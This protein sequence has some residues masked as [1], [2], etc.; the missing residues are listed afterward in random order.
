M[1]EKE[2]LYRKVNTRTRGVRHGGGEYKWLRHRKEESVAGRGSTRAGKRNGRDYTPLFKFLISGVG[3]D[4]DEVYGEAVRRLD[5]PEPIFWL[6]ARNEAEKAA[7][8]RATENTCFS[9]LFIDENNRLAVVDPDLRVE[10]MVP[11][12]AC[13]THSFNGTPF[14]RKFGSVLD[15]NCPLTVHCEQIGRPL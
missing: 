14:I 11:S 12:C 9:G 5:S 1:R 7:V 3:R 6:V 13:C 10:N 4:W 2:P 15:S 8:V